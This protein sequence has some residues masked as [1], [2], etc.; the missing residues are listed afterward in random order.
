MTV[1][2]VSIIG[3]LCTLC[4]IAGVALGAWVSRPRVIQSEPV[5]KPAKQLK[6][7]L[8]HLISP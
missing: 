6:P 7:I 2:N 4:L 1:R 3:A 8:L 5:Y